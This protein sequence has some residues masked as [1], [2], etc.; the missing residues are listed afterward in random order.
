MTEQ[1]KKAAEAAAAAMKS[2][3]AAGTVMGQAGMRPGY[4]GIQ[5]GM[6]A[7]GGPRARTLPGLNDVMKDL[8]VRSGQAEEKKEEAKHEDA[9]VRQYNQTHRQST[10]SAASR[11][12]RDAEAAQ[13]EADRNEA[14][15]APKS[16]SSRSMQL[17]DKGPKGPSKPKATPD[18]IL[19][20]KGKDTG[21]DIE[22]VDLMGGGKS[23]L[24]DILARKAREEAKKRESRGGY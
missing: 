22:G 3:P 12:V 18:L 5:H 1:E 13:R 8:A 11:R 2:R 10:A 14:E 4:I 16:I 7:A 23:G 24:A 9:A 21:R 19:K 15:Q 6:S 17:Q 20:E